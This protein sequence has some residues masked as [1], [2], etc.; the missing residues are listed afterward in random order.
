MMI[1]LR[2]NGFKLI[3]R[4]G[5]SNPIQQIFS[6]GPLHR[7]AKCYNGTCYQGLAGTL[8]AGTLLAGYK[9]W[10]WED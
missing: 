3:K 4:R 2:A 9:V 6:F 7:C 8:L 10:G 1:G 5:L